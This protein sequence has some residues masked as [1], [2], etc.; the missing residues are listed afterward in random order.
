MAEAIAAADECQYAYD[1]REMREDESRRSGA[2][3]QR[4]GKMEE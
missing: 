3:Q 1:S 2:R 4:A